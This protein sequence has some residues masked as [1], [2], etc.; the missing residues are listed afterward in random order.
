MA[1]L[2]AVPDSSFSGVKY[3]LAWLPAIVALESDNADF[4]TSVV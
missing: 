3:F 2:S 1:D 4:D